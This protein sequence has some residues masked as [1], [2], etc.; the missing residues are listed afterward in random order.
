MKDGKR[1]KLQVHYGGD[2]RTVMESEFRYEVVNYAMQCGDDVVIRI[3]DTK[4]EKVE[5]DGRRH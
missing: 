4:E 3:V 1:F 5:K 2:W